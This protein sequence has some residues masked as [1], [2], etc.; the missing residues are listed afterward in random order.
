M[1]NVLGLEICTRIEHGKVYS[2]FYLLQ[3]IKLYN[4][5]ACFNGNLATN[6]NHLR[7]DPHLVIVPIAL[8][9]MGRPIHVRWHHLVAAQ[10]EEILYKMGQNK[11]TFAVMVIY[12]VVVD[13]DDDDDNDDGNDDSQ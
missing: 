12:F 9:D 2:N 4:V 8:T 6:Q 10:V 7:R 3:I 1:G 11:S 5:I 13:G